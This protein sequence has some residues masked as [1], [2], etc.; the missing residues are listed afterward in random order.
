[1]LTYL[2]RFQ[3]AAGLV[4]D[5]DF[6]PKSL[7]RG[8]ELVECERELK[9][10]RELQ[11]D[12]FATKDEDEITSPTGHVVPVPA[13]SLQEL[14][15]A[16]FF[17]EDLRIGEDPVEPARVSEY[18]LGCVREGQPTF[19]TWLARVNLQE[20]Q[21]FCAATIGYAEHHCGFD[22]HPLPPWRSGVMT[23]RDDAK[24][25][26]RPN[27]RWAPLAEFW[28]GHR[29]IKSPPRGSIAIHQR[30]SN[31]TLGHAELLVE[32]S[33]KGIRCIGANEQRRRIHED[34]TFLPW[35]GLVS[36]DASQAL[37]LLGFIV[38][39]QPA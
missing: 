15:L 2:Q 12:V 1:M 38:P 16:W 31:A 14:R 7:A 20:P 39:I 18:L 10:I 23:L 9:A 19:G 17:R 36:A 29:F 28:D 6:G 5:D 11:D 25:G 35:N 4:A 24:A 21:S 37:M 34:K 26:L 32:A 13:Q 3:A 30:R 33:E 22:Q 27:E 8:L